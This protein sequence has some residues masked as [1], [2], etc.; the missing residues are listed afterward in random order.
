MNTSEKEL[1]VA[2]VFHTNRK[3]TEIRNTSTNEVIE[4]FTHS[5][6][7]SEN[8]EAAE[9]WL[10]EHGFVHAGGSDYRKYEPLMT[11]NTAGSDYE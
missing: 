2:L 1:R 5:E 10:G 3:G 8:R 7:C 4:E 9:K 11:G 6:D